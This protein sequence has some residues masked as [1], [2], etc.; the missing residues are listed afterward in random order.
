MKMQNI[1]WK[2]CFKIGVSV[3][4][5]FLCISYFSGA[6]KVIGAV[7]SAAPIIIGFALA[8][9]VN[10]LMS[11]YEGKYFPRSEKKFLI[12]SRRTVC[13]ILA[14]LTVLAIISVVIGLIIPQLVDCVELIIDEAPAVINEFIPKLTKLE[15]LPESVKTFLKD[16]DWQKGISNITDTLTSGLGGVMGTVISTI[17]SVF[18]GVISAFLS[19]VFSVYFLSG[20]DKLLAA[21]KR[22]G[23]HYL[24]ETIYAKIKYTLNILNKSFRRYIVGQCIEALILGVLCTIGMLIFGLPYATMIGALIAF[25]ALIPI[26][27]AYIGGAIG[28]FMILTESP[29]KALFFIIFLV[30]LQQLEGN[31]IYPRVVGT[32]LGLP[33]IWVLAAV[34]VGGGMFGVVGML[35]GVPI[36]AAIYRI[37]KNDIKKERKRKIGDRMMKMREI[38]KG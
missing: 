20:R 33:G 18:S 38:N 4:I 37:L 34:T 7:L 32:S 6:M 11:F 23:K 1:S 25:T 5:L 35:I 15:F 28:G 16:F 17:S 31:L 12:K 29:I 19:V 13:L 24:N 14:Y 26:A 8:Y 2:T 10:I 22:F 21:T 9:I 30:I 36:T 27:G 3:F